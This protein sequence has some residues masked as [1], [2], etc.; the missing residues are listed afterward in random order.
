MST[1]RLL[2]L[3]AVR[4][5]QPVHGYLVRSELISWDVDRWAHLNPGSVYNALRKLSRD[6]LLVETATDPGLLGAA[7]TTA[8]TLTREGE[9]EFVS[10]VRSTLGTVDEFAA[11]S[12]MAGVAFMWALPRAEVL[13][14]LQ[15]RLEALAACAGLEASLE[16]MRCDPEMPEH[17]QEVQRLVNARL[18]GEAQWTR[19]VIERIREGR[20]VFDGETPHAGGH[21][22]TPGHA[23]TRHA[24]ARHAD[25]RHAD[26]APADARGQAARASAR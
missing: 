12:L 21:P 6:G 15:G 20:Y 14:L 7:R 4:I 2:I 5:F 18:S 19:E 17:V 22:H 25:A 16:R 10:L 1:T 8:Y 23:D 9:D 13:T 3:G 24:D 11:D 26:A